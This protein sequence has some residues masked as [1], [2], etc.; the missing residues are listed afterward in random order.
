MNN[1]YT[2]GIGLGVLN[3]LTTNSKVAFDTYQCTSIV[4]STACTTCGSSWFNGND[5]SL[6]V[7]DSYE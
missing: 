4:A 1:N 6:Y 2:G 3:S 5:T 7:E